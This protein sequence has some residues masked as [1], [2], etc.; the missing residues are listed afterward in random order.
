MAEDGEWGVEQLKLDYC[1]S[2]EEE[3]VPVPTLGGND[4]ESCCVP[5]IGVYLNIMVVEAER[6]RR[7]NDMVG[8][9]QSNAKEQNKENS[10]VYKSTKRPKEETGK[11]KWDRI[12]TE[13]EHKE[14]KKVIRMAKRM[15]RDGKMKSI[16][17]YFEK[18]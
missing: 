1:I 17:S 6:K 14:K 18:V 4:N 8:R 5:G 16:D 13:K 12:Q 10:R 2:S 9:A 15:K 7:C 11:E 3:L